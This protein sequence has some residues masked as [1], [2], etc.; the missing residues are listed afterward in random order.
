MLRERETNSAILQ[1][2]RYAFVS[3]LGCD[4]AAPHV[5]NAHGIRARTPRVPWFHSP[6]TPFF[7]FFLLSAPIAARYF[8]VGPQ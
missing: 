4:C 5:R 8:W 7:F 3:R 6:C 2:L 1:V